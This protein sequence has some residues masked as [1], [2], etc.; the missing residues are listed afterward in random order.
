MIAKQ[1]MT[2]STAKQT[3]IKHRDPQTMGAALNYEYTITE[4]PPKK[5]QQFKPPWGNGGGGLK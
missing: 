1:E 4:S 2:L 5:G 3:R